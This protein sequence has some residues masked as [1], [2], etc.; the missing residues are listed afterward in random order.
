[1]KNGTR[2]RQVACITPEFQDR[3]GRE[4]TVVDSFEDEKGNEQV[5]TDDGIWCPG[6]FLEVIEEKA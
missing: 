6:R 1:M 3:V 5:L 2:I 4:A